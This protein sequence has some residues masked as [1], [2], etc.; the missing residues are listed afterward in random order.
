[1]TRDADL[2]KRIADKGGSIVLSSSPAAYREE[3]AV[4]LKRLKD[5]I[6]LSGVRAE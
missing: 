4:E 1:M 5:L 6:A 2:C 3:W